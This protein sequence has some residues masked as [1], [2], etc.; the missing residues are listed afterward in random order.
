M[1]MSEERKT[2][3]LH[4]E[5]VA[6]RVCEIELRGAHLKFVYYNG[7]QALLCIQ[8]GTCHYSPAC[9]DRRRTHTCTFL[10]R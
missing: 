7:K 9:Q 8:Y 5:R 3:T 10:L 4:D 6:R 2:K 1:G